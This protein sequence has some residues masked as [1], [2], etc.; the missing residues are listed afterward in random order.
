MSNSNLAAEVPWELVEWL[1]IL[2]DEY[3]R[4]RAAS[5]IPEDDQDAADEMLSACSMLAD[6]LDG[7]ADP[8]IRGPAGGP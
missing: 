8:A 4:L 1:R 6:H 2:I 5:G 3:R 7:V